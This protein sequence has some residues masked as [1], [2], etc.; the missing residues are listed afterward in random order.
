MTLLILDISKYIIVML[1]ALYVASAFMA[2]KRKDDDFRRGIYVWMELLALG[3]Y[4]LCMGNVVLQMHATGNTEMLKKLS[5]LS[6]FEFIVLLF[7]PI[8]Q[9]AFYR[10]VYRL[11]T[12][13]MQ[14]L[15]GIGFVILARLNPDHA[16]RQFII[17]CVS[18]VLF[19]IVPFII[20]K[21]SFLKKIPFV[22]GGAGIGGLMLV[23]IRGRLINGSKLNYNFFGLIFQPSEVIK[24][25]FAFFIASFLYRKI[26]R[27]R[28]LV[29]AVLAAVHVLTLVA[30]RDLGS[31]LIYFVMYV[32]ML[33]VASGKVHYLIAGIGSGLLAA[34][35]AYFL[36]SHVRSRVQVWLDPWADIDNKGYQ[37]TQSLFGIATGSWFG[38]GLGHGS[39]KTIP[40]VEEDFVFS[41]VA[42][43]L[44]VFFAILLILLC[45]SVVLSALVL[46]S[47][48]KDP[49]YRLVAVGLGICYGIQVVLTIGGGTG[50]IPLTGVTLPLISNGGTS[51]L[52]S[53][54]LFGV[55]QGIYL[56]RMEEYDAEEEVNEKLEAEWEEYLDSEEAAELDEEALAEKEEA[57]FADGLADEEEEET[58][59]QRIRQ[60]RGIAVHAV[61]YALIYLLMLGNIV[62]FLILQGGEAMTN[63][64]NGKLLAILE[65]DN[66]RGTI[67]AADG[68]VLA[69]SVDKNG[70]EVREYPFAEQF[71]QVV[72]YA[73]KGGAGIE[74]RMQRYLITSDVTLAEKLRNDMQNVKDP[75]NNIHTTLLPDLQKT[76]YEALGNY[77][78]A[79]VAT[80]IK[81]WRILAMVSKP[82]YDPNE[83][84]EIWDTLLADEESG[85]LLDRAAQ[86]L[87]PPGSTFKI[88][89]ALEYIRENPDYASYHFDCSGTFTKEDASIQCF[90][91]MVH[92]EE[93]L[94]E[95]FANSC[96]SS[97]ANIGVSLDKER[98]AQTLATMRFNETLKFDLETNPSQ[99]R[100][101]K[102]LNTNDMM[103]ICIGQDKTQVSPLQINL[104]TAAIANGGV[105]M[106]P[107]VIERVVTADGRVIKRYEPKEYGTVMSSEEA[108]IMTELMMAVVDH[109]TGKRINDLPFTVAGKTGSA[110]FS[111]IKAQSHAWFTGFAPAEDPQI[112]VT[113]V[114]ENAGSGGEMAAPVAGKVM[115]EY[116]EE[117][118]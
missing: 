18:L 84:E 22:Y 11:L 64:Y 75:G 10:D 48:L 51:V 61:M 2:L 43:E 111:S 72:G 6:V 106:Q 3:F 107:Y 79:V 74:R 101:G 117:K 66:R 9:R 93:D 57:F 21:W 92:G 45:L 58:T 113:V 27:K 76:A 49:F 42:E 102:E 62:R 71:A 13:Q 99:I 86:G 4:L 53:I 89:T 24:V 52:V 28:L 78:G 29:S 14:M 36:F 97:F 109:G 77:R 15:L 88:F 70:M 114:M 94:T 69:E 25:V 110:E 31:A 34:F 30:S 91:G 23:L 5:L 39:P 112:A 19:L 105:M 98:F 55:L 46:A 104:A 83:I 26:D 65:Q 118:Q 59:E 33:Y 96:N 95:S 1:M 85:L 8:L 67:Y 100:M 82:A 73:A 68:T 115:Q 108:Q 50:F 20:Q 16:R 103:Q 32:A 12:C 35:A 17:I 44:G 87:Y 63:S 38:M 47:R 116:L 7:F 54:V 90:H 41:A 56:L 60:D 37:V 80:D 40:Y 81:T